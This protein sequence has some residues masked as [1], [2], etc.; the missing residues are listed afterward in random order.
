MTVVAGGSGG[1]RKLAIYR[2]QQKFS[3]KFPTDVD[4]SMLIEKQTRCALAIP[5]IQSN[6]NQR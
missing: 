6:R 5:L 4:V 2:R 1:M 3:A